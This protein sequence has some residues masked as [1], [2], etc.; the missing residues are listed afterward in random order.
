MMMIHTMDFSSSSSTKLLLK[1]SSLHHEK[2]S[3]AQVKLLQMGCSVIFKIVHERE[4]Q[5]RRKY[6]NHLAITRIFSE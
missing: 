2:S 4:A 3:E 6:K 5:I 1:I